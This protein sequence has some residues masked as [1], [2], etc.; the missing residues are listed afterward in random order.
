MIAL[1]LC[2]MALY[3]L[4]RIEFRVLEEGNAFMFISSFYVISDKKY[5]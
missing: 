5:G 1:I 3:L 2:I 4:K